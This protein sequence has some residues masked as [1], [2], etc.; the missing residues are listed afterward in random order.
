MKLRYTVPIINILLCFVSIVV[1]NFAHL[2]AIQTSEPNHQYRMWAGFMIGHGVAN[3]DQVFNPPPVAPIPHI[4]CGGAPGG[5]NGFMATCDGELH[6]LTNVGQFRANLFA[7]TPPIQCVMDMYCKHRYHFYNNFPGK[8]SERIMM[9]MAMRSHR[10][11][12]LQNPNYIVQDY[13]HH[14]LLRRLINEP[15]YR[16]RANVYIVPERGNDLTCQQNQRDSIVAALT[17]VN[18]FNFN[19]HANHNGVADHPIVL[20]IEHAY[21]RFFISIYYSPPP[22]PPL[23]NQKGFNRPNQFNYR[24]L[25]QW[26]VLLT[27]MGAQQ[28]IRN[29]FKT[30]L[31]NAATFDCQTAQVLSLHANIVPGHG[32]EKYF[33][34]I[35]P[36]GNSLV[37]TPNVGVSGQWCNHGY[38][39]LFCDFLQAP[40]GAFYGENPGL[41]LF[42]IPGIIP[43]CNIAQNF[44]IPSTLYDMHGQVIT[45]PY[46][47]A[48]TG[49]TGAR[50]SNAA[51][52]NFLMPAA[53]HAHNLPPANI[54]FGA[55]HVHNVPHLQ[56]FQPAA[57]HNVPP[58]DEMDLSDISQEF[59][60]TDEESEYISQ[61]IL[62]GSSESDEITE[63]FE[64][65]E[66][67]V[68]SEEHTEYDSNDYEFWG[69]GCNQNE[70]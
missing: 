41:G 67:E 58:A 27:A 13:S 36:F 53:N 3:N 52:N 34:A 47:K 28:T 44:I 51:Y 54:L 33:T 29:A 16:T 50:L 25:T 35:A 18:R 22:P 12:L 46:F 66:D 68:D 48:H 70:N 10:M 9:R 60:I 31:F 15:P 55:V 8:H 38:C 4:T 2:Q 23:K 32:F 37:A 5:A 61:E 19:M 39:G 59:E 26:D 64:I 7:L 40:G 62:I 49:C 69:P 24:G 11:T 6:D 21:A 20:I 45:S 56:A 1:S 17:A 57:L 63:Q 14:V 43:Q 30:A 42:P 65:D